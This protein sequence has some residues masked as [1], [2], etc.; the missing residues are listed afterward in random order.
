MAD[1]FDKNF[2]LPRIEGENLLCCPFG[3]DT[4]LCDSCFK[5]K[6]PTTN[7]VEKGLID[8]KESESLL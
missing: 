7:P 8:K 4:E 3:K 2:Y 1:Q 5:T 6:E